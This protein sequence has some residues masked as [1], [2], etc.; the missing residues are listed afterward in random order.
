MKKQLLTLFVATASLSHVAQAAQYFSADKKIESQLCSIS[1][2][3]GFSAARKV[4]HQHGI[5][6]S[7]HSQSIL[8]N[9]QDIRDIA[10]KESNTK[11]NVKVVEVFATNDQTE[12]QLCVTAVKQGLTPVREKIGNLNSLR[13]N[14]EPVTD[15]VKR[16]QNAAI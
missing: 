8:C 4:A 9:G 13:C 10:K 15:F 1:A 6:I 5:F 7:R 14:G 16:Y 3:E 2:N 11:R 12:T